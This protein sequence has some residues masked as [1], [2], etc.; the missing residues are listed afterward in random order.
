MMTPRI[1]FVGPMIG[2]H[3]G[4]VTTQD[5]V[6]ANL[7]RS[8]GRAVLSVSHK[9]G[10]LARVIDIA[11][12]L[13]AKRGDI[14]ILCLSVYGG[15]SFVVEDIASLLGKLFGFRIIMH[16]HGGALPQFLGRFPGWARR[17]LRRA[18]VMVVPSKY[19]SRC[20]K[21]FGCELRIIPNVVDISQYSYRQMRELRPR[22]LWMR[23]F[24]DI[25]NPRMALRVLRRMLHDGFAASLVMAGQDKGMLGTLR[26]EAQEMGV[27]GAVSF[28][29]FLDVRAKRR[30]GEEC[31]IFISTN[32]ID[33]TPVA[34]IEAWAMGLPVVST[35]VGGVPDLVCDGE[36]GLLVDSDDD[37]SMAERVSELVR[38]ARLAR[39]LSESG[40]QKAEDCSWEKVRPQWEGL[41][42][43]IASIQKKE[44]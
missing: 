14:D 27:D 30:Y 23:S 42:Q 41:F 39:H 36:T 34:L 8:D 4:C 25:W 35:N 18:D 33:N 3:P 37:K 16:F 21:G 10:R 44:A 24:H 20:L 31:D 29:G 12:T 40:R 22:L 28:P 43:Q 7:F 1:C 26:K 17:V 9:L 5:E 15:P 11:W 32:R 13:L 19:L 6:L 2:K 38:D